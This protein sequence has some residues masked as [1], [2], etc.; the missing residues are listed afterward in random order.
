MINKVAF[1]CIVTCLTGC[2]KQFPHPV[3]YIQ[4]DNDVNIA[5]VRL[6]GAPMSYSIFQKNKNDTFVGGDVLQ[7]NRWVNV[8]FGSTKDMGFQKIKNRDYSGKY[9][10]T[11]ILPEIKTRIQ[12]SLYGGCKVSLE[13]TP[14][15][16]GLYEVHYN[17]ND[18]SG[19]CV[20]YIKEIVFDSVN[21][22]Y[23]E[24]NVK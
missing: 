8:T 16:Q 3:T 20:L 1:F 24:E 23:V 18:L 21:S 2:S 14:K 15:K 19:Y 4:P 7:H 10:E 11:L 12:H 17:Y 5:K 6:M 13:F 22:I 9:Y